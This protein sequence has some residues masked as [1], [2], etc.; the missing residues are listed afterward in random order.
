MRIRTVV[1]PPDAGLAIALNRRWFLAGG[2]TLVL[3]AIGWPLVVRGGEGA[4][5]AMASNPN[6]DDPH[7]TLPRT[8][9][10]L[11]EGIRGGVHIGA[12]MFVSIGGEPRADSG[13]GES[14]PGVVCPSSGDGTITGSMSS[15][16]A[17]SSRRPGADAPRSAPCCW[18]SWSAAY[19]TR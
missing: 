2:R 5:A 12:Q 14:R 1:D 3:G 17:T 6:L 7:A 10:L 11:E 4:P 15:S 13:I 19:S 9:A 18:C 16:T 8:V